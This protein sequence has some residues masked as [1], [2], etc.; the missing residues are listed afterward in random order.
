MINSICNLNVLKQRYRLQGVS[1]K[2]GYT[3]C[4]CAPFSIMKRQSICI[5]MDIRYLKNTIGRVPVVHA[6]VVP[7][8][9]YHA[10]Y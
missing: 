4:T 3:T 8:H 2:R 1:V 7:D 10:F 5:I 9:I 6:S